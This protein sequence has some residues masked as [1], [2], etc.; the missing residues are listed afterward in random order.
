MTRLIYKIFRPKVKLSEVAEPKP[1][2]AAARVLNDALKRA[3]VEQKSV[4]THAA[5]IRSSSSTSSFTRT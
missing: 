4:S 1:S 5:S 3:Y 2:K